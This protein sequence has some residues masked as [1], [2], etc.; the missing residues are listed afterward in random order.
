P[1]AFELVVMAGV[2]LGASLGHYCVGRA[3]KLADTGY[4]VIFDYLRLPVVALFAFVLFDELPSMAVLAGAAMI[5]GGA[6]YSSRHQ[7]GLKSGA[8]AR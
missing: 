6:V 7:A 1:T 4:L 3:M 2:G 8:S 5:A